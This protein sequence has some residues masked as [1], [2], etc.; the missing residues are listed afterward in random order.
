M[1]G[2]KRAKKIDPIAGHSEEISDEEF[3]E[4]INNGDGKIQRVERIVTDAS[5][6][7]EISRG[8]LGSGWGDDILLGLLGGSLSFEAKLDAANAGNANSMVEV[9]NAYL[10]GD[11]V[12][13]ALLSRLCEPG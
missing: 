2:K 1:K 10:N 3:R 9:A 8:P 7:E 6:G 11:E 4:A 12:K 13:T 5:S